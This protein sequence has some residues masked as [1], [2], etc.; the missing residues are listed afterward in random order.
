M[1]TANAA[2]RPSEEPFRRWDELK[3]AMAPALHPLV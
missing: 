2:H 3:V 1:S